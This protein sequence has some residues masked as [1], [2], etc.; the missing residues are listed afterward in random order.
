MWASRQGSGDGI[1]G[2]LLGSDAPSPSLAG[3]RNFPRP[4]RAKPH[5]LDTLPRP[6]RGASPRRGTQKALCALCPPPPKPPERFR[7]RAGAEAGNGAACGV[8]AEGRGESTPSPFLGVGAGAGRGEAQALFT[9]LPRVG[10]G[11]WLGEGA[12]SICR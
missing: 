8:Q 5:A 10:K 11:T 12:M 3:P 9:A 4:Q 2:R 1:P 7:N 6:G